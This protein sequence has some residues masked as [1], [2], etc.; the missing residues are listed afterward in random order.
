MKENEFLQWRKEQQR[1]L[2]SKHDEEIKFK[3]SNKR[4]KAIKKAIDKNNEFLRMSK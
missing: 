4:L 3:E 1:L 2:Q